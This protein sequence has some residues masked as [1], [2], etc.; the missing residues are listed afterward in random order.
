MCRGRASICA[1]GGGLFTARGVLCVEL[2]GDAAIGVVL[3]GTCVCRQWRPIALAWGF[4]LL[5]MRLRAHEG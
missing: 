5:W 4:V 1:A 3:Y 2:S